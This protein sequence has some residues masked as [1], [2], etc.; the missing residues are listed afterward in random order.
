MHGVLEKREETSQLGSLLLFVMPPP[1]GVVIIPA[2][3]DGFNFVGDHNVFKVSHMAAKKDG[4][5]GVV[6]A[7]GSNKVKRSY[8]S[9]IL[10]FAPS[11]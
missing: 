2:E 11:F 1:S 4:K 5:W 10:Y 9:F 8:Y 7:D 6:M 3:Y